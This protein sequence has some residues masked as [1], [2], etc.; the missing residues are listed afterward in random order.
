VS[1]QSQKEDPVHSQVVV[2]EL[3]DRL[4]VLDPGRVGGR[5]LRAELVNT[6]EQVTTDETDT[7][8]GEH[9]TNGPDQETTK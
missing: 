2:D 5:T 4:A 7:I 3:D 8:Q 6:T 9:R 1:D